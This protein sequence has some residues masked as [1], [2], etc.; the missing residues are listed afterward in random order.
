MKQQR[1]GG[2]PDFEEETELRLAVAID[3]IVAS[4]ARSKA[5]AGEIGRLKTE[6][7]AILAQIEANLK[8]VA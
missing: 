5:I 1:N 3:E 7:R 4:Q 2:T 6:T 8:H